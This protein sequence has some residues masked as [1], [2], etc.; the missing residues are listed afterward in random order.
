VFQLS[1]TVRALDG[2]AIGT[3]LMMMMMMMMI[4]AVDQ[5]FSSRNFP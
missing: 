2:A 5:Q 1:K 3:G 4:N